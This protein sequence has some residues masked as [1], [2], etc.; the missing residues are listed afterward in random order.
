MLSYSFLLPPIRLDI[1]VVEP[2]FCM[3]FYD[4]MIIM[5]RNLIKLLWYKYA[6]GGE[7]E[8]TTR[9]VMSWYSS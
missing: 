8:L 2:K 9:K 6:R 5:M 7:I 4:L 1:I 3:I